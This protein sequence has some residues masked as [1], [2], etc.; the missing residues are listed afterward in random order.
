MPPGRNAAKDA[1]DDSCTLYLTAPETGDHESCGFAV[2]VSK[3]PQPRDV[4]VLARPLRRRDVVASVAEVGDHAEEEREDAAED[5]QH[6]LQLAEGIALLSKVE[7]GDVDIAFSLEFTKARRRKPSDRSL[8]NIGP[9]FARSPS[10]GA[11]TPYADAANA[12]APSWRMPMYSISPSCTRRRIAS[13]TAAAAR[14]SA[15]TTIRSFAARVAPAAGL[16]SSWASPAESLPKAINLSRCS[17]RSRSITARWLSTRLRRSGSGRKRG[18]SESHVLRP[19][20]T[21]PP[22]V[23]LV[24]A[25][26]N[27]LFFSLIS[28]SFLVFRS[29][30]FFDASLPAAEVPAITLMSTKAIFESWGNGIG[31]AAGLGAGCVAAGGCAGGACGFGG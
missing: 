1:C 29:D 31:G 3:G 24:W 16:L 8:T 18:G 6:A 4:P 2:T 17:F 10:G 21:V 5:G 23:S 30:S 11:C 22:V 26:C 15:S 12:A 19:M 7:R 9:T 25:A 28:A 27:C 14:S 13:A 20:T